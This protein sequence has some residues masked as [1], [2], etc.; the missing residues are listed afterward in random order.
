MIK[1]SS[2]SVVLPIFNDA[3]AF[4]SKFPRIFSIL[5]KLPNIYEIEII[6]V[7]NGSSD[8][9]KDFIGADVIYFRLDKPNYG[10]AIN[11]GIKKS[12][13]EF[14]YIL[15]IDQFDVSF[16]TWSWVHRESYSIIFSS[17]KL[18]PSLNYQSQLRSFLS[19][20]L[21]S[22]LQ[23][24]FKLPLTDTHGQKLLNKKL[25]SN[26]LKGILADRGQYDVELI[27]KLL[28]GGH[29]VAQ[30]PVPYKELRPSRNNI[31]KKILWNIFAL[32]KL[33]FRLRPIRYKSTQLTIFSRKR[34][35]RENTEIKILK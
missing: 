29:E 26:L 16:I 2:L 14:I 3:K 19:W 31:L 22:L 20:G 33:Y 23:L 5:K 15:D 35:L 12:T 7:D 30:I 10:H 8:N 13:C 27:Y 17:K 6:V 34:I 11:F 4:K 24:L 1:K 32:I 21:N 9:L 28:S 25:T 18:D